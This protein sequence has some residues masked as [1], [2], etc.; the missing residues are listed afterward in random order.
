MLPLIKL[1][2]CYFIKQCFLYTFL[3]TSTYQ[4]CI[5]HIVCVISQMHLFFGTSF[6]LYNM[7]CLLV[8]THRNKLQIIYKVEPEET[9]YKSE[10]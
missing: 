9:W 6:V 4:L 5:V 2:N 1:F 10:E 8:N 7:A 3:L